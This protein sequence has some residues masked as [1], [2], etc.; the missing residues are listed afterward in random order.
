MLLQL[1]QAGEP[2]L[3]KTAK[4]VTK[5]ALNQ[6][7]TQQTIELMIDTLRD[8]PGVGLAAPQVGENLQIIIIEDKKAYHKKLPAM[9]LKEQGRKPVP[10]QVLVN[11]ILKVTKSDTKQYFEGCLSINGY[12]AVVPRAFEVEVRALDRT[13]QPVAFTASGWHARILQHE[14]DHLTG[15]LYTDR[16]QVRSF[17][18]E[19]IFNKKW[20]KAASAMIKKL[21]HTA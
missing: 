7:H 14:I 12:R 2:V 4:K 9:L 18:T 17:M 5:V 6:A 15:I 16:M 21:D 13:G 20:S 11:P 10:L 19:A 1:Y 8:H 3:R